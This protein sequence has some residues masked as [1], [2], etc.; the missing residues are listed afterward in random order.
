MSLDEYLM[1][2]GVAIDNA[3]RNVRIFDAVSAYG[4]DAGVL[5]HGRAL[6]DAVRAAN[7]AQRREYGA[8][9]AATAALKETWARANRVYGDHRKIAAIVFRDAPDRL[10]ALELD[11]PKRKDFSGWLTQARLFYGNLLANPDDLAAMD[12]FRITR[13]KL[14]EGQALIEQTEALNRAQQDAKGRARQ[15]TRARNAALA[16]LQQWMNDFRTI[17]KITLADDPQ[18]LESLQLAVVP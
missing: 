18:L 12:R 14:V 3:R 1:R 6:L 7:D 10:T 16:E 4:Y 17:A 2:A 15:A 5:Q 13:E 11:R 8:Q 9:Y